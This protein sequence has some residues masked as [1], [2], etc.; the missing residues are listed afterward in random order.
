MFKMPDR[1]T[2]I[3]DL[4]FSETMINRAVQKLYDIF[5]DCS[6]NFN[7]ASNPIK[8]NKHVYA[9]YEFAPNA[10]YIH[11]WVHYIDNNEIKEAPL[12]RLPFDFLFKQETELLE[13]KE[14]NLNE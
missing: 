3:K 4:H 11:I 14:N 6:H 2:K 7:G 1:I 12:L 10:P 5:K 9:F 8:T 13:I